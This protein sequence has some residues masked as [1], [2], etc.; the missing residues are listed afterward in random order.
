MGGVYRF[1]AADDPHH[2]NR[3]RQRSSAEGESQARRAGECNDLEH[4]VERHGSG[5][6]RDTVS[7][8][9]DAA[10]VGG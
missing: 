8:R 10:R 3:T 6:E 2:E 9:W 5:F 7:Y 4:L 1:V